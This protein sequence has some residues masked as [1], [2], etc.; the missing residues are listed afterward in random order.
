MV[1]HIKRSMEAYLLEIDAVRVE[2][3]LTAQLLIQHQYGLTRSKNFLTSPTGINDS[4]PLIDADTQAY[5]VSFS[6]KA[7]GAQS[8][9]NRSGLNAD[10]IAASGAFDAV[11]AE[12]RAL[13][14]LTRSRGQLYDIDDATGI[15]K[16][17]TY[18]VAD[19]AA[20][21]VS[22]AALIALLG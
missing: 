14:V 22:V 1:A 3:K 21:R 20:L 13:I 9:P 15:F 17:Q 18:S 4:G 8:Y 7:S 10:I 19:M 12:T 5:L 11:T 16:H 6:T 2:D